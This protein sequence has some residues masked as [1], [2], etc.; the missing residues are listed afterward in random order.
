[1]YFGFIVDISE[2]I[3]YTSKGMV[4]GTCTFYYLSHTFFWS[5]NISILF[6]NKFII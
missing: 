5:V 4:V 2:N 1:M 3:W 6:L